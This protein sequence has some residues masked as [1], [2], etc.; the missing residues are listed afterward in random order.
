MQMYSELYHQAHCTF[1][2]NFQFLN[3]AFLDTFDYVQNIKKY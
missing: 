1:N 3:V 2:H